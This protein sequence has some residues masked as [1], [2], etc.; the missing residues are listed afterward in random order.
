VARDSERSQSPQ[1]WGTAWHW[2]LCTAASAAYL[3]RLTVTDGTPVRF[4]GALA[5]PNVYL[6]LGPLW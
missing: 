4:G 1:L 2:Y 3:R 5:T 6:H